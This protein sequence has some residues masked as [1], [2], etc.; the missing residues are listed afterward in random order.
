MSDE[1]RSA[2]NVFAKNRVLKSI[3]IEMLLNASGEQAI[4]KSSLQVV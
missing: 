3:T 1:L 2:I 4:K